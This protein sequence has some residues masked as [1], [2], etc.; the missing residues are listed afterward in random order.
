MVLIRCR[1][2]AGHCR[3]LRTLLCRRRCRISC[4][5]NCRRLSRLTM[6]CNLIRVVRWSA[7]ATQRVT[8]GLLLT[9]CG[10]LAFPF[11]RLGCGGLGRGRVFRTKLRACAPMLI[12]RW[13]GRLLFMSGL[14]VSG[15]R[16]VRLTVSLRVTCKL[17]L[18]SINRRLAAKRCR[19]RG[20]SGRV[21]KVLGRLIASWFRWWESVARLRYRIGRCELGGDSELIGF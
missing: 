20:R 19:L 15:R 21:M 12:T 7:V 9:R 4:R 10:R 5:L 6:R 14:V 8:R 3:T 13:R 17:S 16:R 2:S 18:G 11:V 1:G